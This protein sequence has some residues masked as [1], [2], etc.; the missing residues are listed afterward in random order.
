VDKWFITRLLTL[1]ACFVA[2][3][4]TL[5]IAVATHHL[6]YRG[7][8][9]AV[10]S[11]ATIMIVAFTVF[12]TKARKRNLTTQ[13][14]NAVLDDAT[15]SRLRNSIRICQLMILVFAAG[16][17]RGLIV[18][19]RSRPRWPILVGIA[20]NLLWQYVLITAI[21]KAQKRLKAIPAWRMN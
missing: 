13:T 19:A 4:F 12:F 3:L 21:R 18:L 6:S 11:T 14:S 10:L 9:F 1:V 2:A 15:Q 16:L 20:I 5:M 8:A 7:F 17:I